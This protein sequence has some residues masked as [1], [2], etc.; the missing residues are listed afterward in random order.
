MSEYQKQLVKYLQSTYQ[1][2]LA[3]MVVGPLIND[4][5]NSLIFIVGFIMSLVCI[6]WGMGI[7]GYASTRGKT[8][9]VQ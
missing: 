8:W 3:G 6:F 2:L 4:E 5:I 1:V 9:K 7:V